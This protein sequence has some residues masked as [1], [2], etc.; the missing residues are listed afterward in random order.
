MKVSELEIKRAPEELLPVVKRAIE[1]PYYCDPTKKQIGCKFKY[2]DGREFNVVVSDTVEGNPDWKELI[3][4]FT[5]EEIQANTDVILERSRRE[6][7]TRER[8]DKENSEKMKSDILFQCKLE[9]FEIEEVKNSAD[10]DLKSKIRKSKNLT[11]VQAY[12]AA[13][14]M[15]ELSQG[16]VSE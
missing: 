10:R 15:K 11:E 9:A 16:E 3:E 2:E 14:I 5:D 6:A 12:T 4:T 7:D 1:E 8:I 13:L